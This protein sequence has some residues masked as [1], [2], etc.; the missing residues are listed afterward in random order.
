MGRVCYIHPAAQFNPDEA[1]EDVA[2]AWRIMTGV[3][4]RGELQYTCSRAS[5]THGRD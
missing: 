1:C 5:L 2:L 3:E 4:E